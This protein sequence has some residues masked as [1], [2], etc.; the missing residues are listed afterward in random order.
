MSTCN[1]LDLQTLGSQPV[2][3]KNLHDHCTGE[4][5]NFVSPHVIKS[6]RIR[7]FSYW[8]VSLENLYTMEDGM[9]V[10]MLPQHFPPFLLLKK[11]QNNTQRKRSAT[12]QRFPSNKLVPKNQKIKKEDTNLERWRDYKCKRWVWWTWWQPWGVMAGCVHGH[13]VA[14]VYGGGLI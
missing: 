8:P 3:P 5:R 7:V 14:W 9:V 10:R 11:K 13:L 6:T 1:R 4:W 12:S 2:M